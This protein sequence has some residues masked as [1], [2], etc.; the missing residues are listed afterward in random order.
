METL[1]L[2]NALKQVYCIHKNIVSDL[3]AKIDVLTL[4]NINLK[5]NQPKEQCLTCIQLQ[6][7]N[8]TLQECFNALIKEKDTTIQLLRA[9]ILNQNAETPIEILDSKSTSELPA[10]R[11]NNKHEESHSS[12]STDESRNESFTKEENSNLK[13]SS[14]LR[15]TREKKRR[16]RYQEE[17]PETKR[18]KT[19]LDLSHTESIEGHTSLE[20]NSS[21]V[22][23]P[24]T[25]KLESQTREENPVVLN[26]ESDE[27]AADVL[28]QNVLI[29]PE[30]IEM[31]DFLKTGACGHVSPVYGDSITVACRGASSKPHVHKCNP[32]SQNLTPKK[33]VNKF[34]GQ[35]TIH[36]VNEETK[37]VSCIS[38]KRKD[39][40]FTPIVR[41]EEKNNILLCKVDLDTSSPSKSTDAKDASS[42]SVVKNTELPGR[43]KSSFQN[44]YQSTLSQVFPEHLSKQNKLKSKL[45]NVEKKHDLPCFVEEKKRHEAVSSSHVKESEFQ[46]PVAPFCTKTTLARKDVI[47]SAKEHDRESSDVLTSDT[48]DLSGSINP[49]IQLSEFFNSQKSV[50]NLD[51]T[52]APSL[53]SQFYTAN[54]SL[55]S[56]GSS[57]KTQPASS[58]LDSDSSRTLVNESPN[59]SVENFNVAAEQLGG[60]SKNQ[61]VPLKSDMLEETLQDDE[62]GEEDSDEEIVGPSPQHTLRGSSQL[63]CSI[64]SSFKFM[65]KHKQT[66]SMLGLKVDKVLTESQNSSSLKDVKSVYKNDED[67]FIDV[68]IQDTAEEVFVD[69]D[70][71]LQEIDRNTLVDPNTDLAQAKT[72]QEVQVE[73]SF[74]DSFDRVPKKAVVEF[75]HVQVVRKKDDRK[76]LEGFSCQEC[77]EYYKNSGLSDEAMKQKM[78]ECSRHRAKYI[79]PSTPEH[80]WSIGFPD[81]AEL[82]D[83]SHCQKSETPMKSEKN[84]RRRRRLE[85]RFKSRNEEDF[86]G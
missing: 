59:Y 3:N 4:E 45:M 65:P 18:I 81:T 16:N 47:N 39:G 24:E 35:D 75:P 85:K 12:P 14:K 51:E 64:P 43:Q 42:L 10:S 11:A 55:G 46:I 27:E 20:K 44:N 8:Q 37:N 17:R 56:Q 69:L 25:E 61:T 9:K 83:K 86:P 7:K 40:T 48:C 68:D 53:V 78:N 5:C 41:A 28:S 31:E 52:V 22:L 62:N 74:M 29:V 38:S 49:N 23:V 6:E 76:K 57:S 63:H 66:H 84:P 13:H 34:P 15:L 2:T 72:E 1:S 26:G 58:Q 67:N 50:D 77:Y 79:P 80:F 71:A 60:D 32:V 82:Y 70:G 30:T 73:Q 33:I 19:L 36:S 21:K 54:Q